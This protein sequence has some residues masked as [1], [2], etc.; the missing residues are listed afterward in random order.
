M[1]VLQPIIVTSVGSINGTKGM[2]RS[3]DWHT[4][5]V[6]VRPTSKTVADRGISIPPHA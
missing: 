6:S 1:I 5:E 3:L 4:A 2:R